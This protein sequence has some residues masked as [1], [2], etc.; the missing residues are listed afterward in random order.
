MVDDPAPQKREGLLWR[1]VSACI[2][3]IFIVLVLSGPDFLF[4]LLGIGVIIRSAYEAFF[5]LGDRK[6]KTAFLCCAF[7]LLV[8]LGTGC[9][10][11]LRYKGRAVFA[12]LV[13]VVSAGDIGA[14]GI[15][16]M[17]GGP[18]IFPKTSPRKTWSGSLGGLIFAISIGSAWNPISDQ[19]NVSVLASGV[20]LS[21]LL[22]DYLES[23]VK[24]HLGLKD[25]GSFIPG[26][27]GLLDRLDS[28]L[29]AALFLWGVFYLKGF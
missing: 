13:L 26:H 17:I 28:L 6:G 19:V 11:A 22:G 1:T 5:I 29:V 23:F 10:I 24:R 8:C 12:W 25:F 21:G 9:S 16:R 14:Y 7:F 4:F 27:G 3:V 20:A 18:K 15:G 2:L